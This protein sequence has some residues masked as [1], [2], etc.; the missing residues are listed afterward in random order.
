LIR[1]RFCC[2]IFARHEVSAA[3][4]VSVA[5][6]CLLFVCCLFG[7][8]FAD[9][10]PKKQAGNRVG[11][12]DAINETASEPRRKRRKPTERPSPGLDSRRPK[13]RRLISAIE[14]E[15]RTNAGPSSRPFG[16]RAEKEAAKALE[17][18]AHSGR[19]KSRKLT[20][21]KGGEQP[22]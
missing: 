20:A 3:T 22:A 5:F 9:G 4:F 14:A 17:K 2:A 1:Q 18:R 21:Q 19:R 16:E 10:R 6:V 12:L 8:R 11:N 13:R 15:N 7:Q